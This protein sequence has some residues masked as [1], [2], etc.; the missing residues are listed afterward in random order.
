ML[1]FV[2]RPKLFRKLLDRGISPIF[3]RIF[4]SIYALQKIKVNWNGDI[5]DFFLTSNGVLQGVTISAILFCIYC[6]NLFHLLQESSE[7]CWIR[8]SYSRIFGYRD[9]NIL[10]ALSRSS[11][12]EMLRIVYTCVEANL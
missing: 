6:D 2:S 4:S 1:D 10:L 3:V 12:Q 11:L 8:G 7:G 5:S 9:D